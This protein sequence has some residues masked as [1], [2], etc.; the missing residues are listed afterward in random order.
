MGLGHSSK[1][2]RWP[3]WRELGAQDMVGDKSEHGKLEK[4]HY[5]G[6]CRPLSDMGVPARSKVQEAEHL[7]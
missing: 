1:E 2:A 3:E 7:S 6:L 5:E 4:V